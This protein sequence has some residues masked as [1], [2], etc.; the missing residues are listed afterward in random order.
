MNKQSEKMDDDQANELRMLFNEVEQG[1]E[2]RDETVD[3]HEMI[4]DNAKLRTIDVLNLPPRKEIHMNNKRTK[5]RLSRPFIRFVFISLLVIAIL[6][7]A[8]YL[9]DGELVAFF[10][11]L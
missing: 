8:L 3:E 10:Y 7:G 1:N 9:W 4:D 2:N 6:I 11:D 5:L